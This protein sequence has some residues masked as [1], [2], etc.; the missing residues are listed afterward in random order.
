MFELIIFLVLIIAAL[1][2]AFWVI[3]SDFKKKKFKTRFW[4]YTILCLALIFL[5][6][7]VVQALFHYF[8]PPPSGLIF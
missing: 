4:L 2:G 1:A 7:I 5:L 6:V 8:E 3:I